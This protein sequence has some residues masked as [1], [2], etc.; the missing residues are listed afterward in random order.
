MFKLSKIRQFKH[1]YYH[2]ILRTF[3]LLILFLLIFDSGLVSPVSKD[4]SFNTQQF[5][6][7]GI[8]MYAGVKPTEINLLTAELG[9]KERELAERERE[10][11]EREIAVNLQTGSRGN[12]NA[13]TYILASILFILLLL[14]LLNYFVDYL[15]YKQ[16]RLISSV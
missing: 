9:I 16:F 5:L 7:S 15:R 6:A 13:S 8:G 3:A 4:L 11:V 10:L 1:S 14:I 2:R 12:F